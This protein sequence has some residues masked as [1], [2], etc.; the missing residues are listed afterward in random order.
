MNGPREHAAGWFAKGESDL[1]AARR[2]LESEEAYDVVCFHAQQAAEKFVKAILALRG[3]EITRTHNLDQ[4]RQQVSAIDQSI[5]IPAAVTTLTPYAVQLRY[6]HDFWPDER[7]ARAA[8][9]IAT[10]VRRVGEKAL[11]G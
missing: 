4:L 8:V 2:L 5:Q 3:K 1:Q 9:D 7:T 6:D 11:A 10:E